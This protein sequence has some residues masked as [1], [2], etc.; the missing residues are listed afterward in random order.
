M[1]NIQQLTSL[2]QW[3][4]VRKGTTAKPLLVFKHSTSCSVSAGAH[5]EL[6]RFIEDDKANTVD[7]AIVHVIEDRPVSNTIA[8]QLD[9]K[10]ASPQAILVQD[11]QPVWNT[12]HWHI[13]YSFL[14]EKLGS[15]VNNS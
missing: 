8:E 12:S 15:S 10:H 5:E 3:E 9:I 2:D 4:Q 13:T 1:A 14:S 11:G 7:Y 6:M